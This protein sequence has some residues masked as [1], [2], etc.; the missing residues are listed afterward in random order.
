MAVE[1]EDLA[2]LVGLTIAVE[3]EDLAGLVGLTIAVEDE[4]STGSKRMTGSKRI[5]FILVGVGVVELEGSESE[6]VGGVMSWGGGWVKYK[7]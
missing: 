1:D 4:D 2:G 3:D 6:I 5:F 7:L